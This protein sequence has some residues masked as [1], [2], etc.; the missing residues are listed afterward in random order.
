VSIGLVDKIVE[1]KKRG[2]LRKV[3]QAAMKKT[4]EM[5]EMKKLLAGIYTRINKVKVPKL[6]L[7]PVAKEPVDPHLVVDD[8][9]AE[10]EKPQQVNAEASPTLTGTEHS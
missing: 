10:E 9:P 4:P 5:D 1:P 8:K 3:R 2:N 6:E 7:N